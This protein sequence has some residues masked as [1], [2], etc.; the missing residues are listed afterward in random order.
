MPGY[1]L[2]L[3]KRVSSDPFASIRVTGHV[4]DPFEVK[5]RF[6]SHA[7]IKY[8]HMIY[9]IDR[10]DETNLSTVLVLRDSALFT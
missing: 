8:Q 10:Q 5:T 9:Q 6:L 2:T 4:L 7:S 1:L 3:L